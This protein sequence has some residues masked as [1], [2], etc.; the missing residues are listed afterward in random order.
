M[1][2]RLVIVLF[3]ALAIATLCTVFV[4]RLVGNRLGAMQPKTTRLIVAGTDIKLGSILRDVDLTTAEFVGSV[5]KGAIL[6]KQDAIGRGVVSNLYQ[7]EPVIDS[8]LA[9]VGS[10][11]GLAATIRQGMRACAVKVDEVV[12]V[13]GFVTPGMRVDVLIS[14]NPPGA[15]NPAEGP[16]VRT[17]FQNIEVLSAGTDIQKDGEGKPQQV[18]VVNLLVTPEQAELLS[19]ASTQTHIQ[20]VLRN[21]LDTQVAQVSGS[22]L[23]HLY[24]DPNAK[25]T[26]KP[27]A[28]PRRVTRPVPQAQM[29]LVEVFNGS[30]RSEEKFVTAE[31]K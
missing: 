28:V 14:G 9:A 20:L 22:A 4:Y 11:G 2:R 18:Q 5:P 12:G 17:L 24:A 16:K 3:S 7:G 25:P 8:R 29:Y 6:K 21:P 19:L 27:L 26:L 23:T 31:G 30:K 1:N 15:V 10:G 13:A